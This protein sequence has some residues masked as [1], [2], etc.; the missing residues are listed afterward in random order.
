[1]GTVLDFLATLPT[2][3]SNKFIVGQHATTLPNDYDDYVVG[4]GNATGYYP[5]IY[6]VSFQMGSGGSNNYESVLNEVLNHWEESELVSV[7]WNPYNPWTGEFYGSFGSEINITELL[8]PGTAANT[9]WMAWLSDLADYLEKFEQA[10]KIVLFRPMCEMNGQWYWWGGR[11]QSDYIALWQQVHTYMSDTRGIDNIIWVYASVASSHLSIPFDY[12]YPG[13]AYVDVFGANNYDYDW[14]LPFELNQLGMRYPKVMA[15]PEAG[16]SITSAS[17]N[18]G[19]WDNLTYRNT[20]QSDY[21][22]ISYFTVYN[23]YTTWNNGSVDVNL[24]IVDNLNATALM[25][26]PLI[27]TLEEMPF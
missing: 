18:G 15:F 11:P 9:T 3:S 6:E 14:V 5:G 20:L 8:T 21:P 10:G 26:D 4:L 13:D 23:S 25:S 2:Q 1:V 16:N 17:N 19:N 12:Y 7:Q 24:A 22:R 27:R